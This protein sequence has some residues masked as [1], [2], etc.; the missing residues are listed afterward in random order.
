MPKQRKLWISLAIIAG[1]IILVLISRFATRGSAEK[2]TVAKVEARTIRSSILASGQLIYTNPVELKPEII[3]KIS[4]IPVVEG[5]MV[6]KDQV[7]LRIDP[8]LYQAAVAQATAGVQQARLAIESQK[9]S[10]ANLQLQWNRQQSL[11]KQHLV[12]ANS[13]DQLTN[14][15]DIAKVQLDSQKEAARIAEAQLSQAQQNLSKTVIRSPIDGMV[16]S[17]PVKVGETVITGTNIPGSTL[18]EIADPV[19]VLADVQVDEADIANVKLGEEADINAVSYPNDTFH[20]KV[21]FIAASVTSSTSVSS[22]A[23]TA[24]QGV[25]FE[26]KIGLTDKKLPRVRP[27]MSCRAEIYTQSTPNAIAVPLQAVLYEN[28]PNSKSLEP[29]SGAYVYVIRDGKA[30]KVDVTTGVSSDT[31]QEIASGLKAGET[32][33]TGPYTVLHAL[34]DGVKVSVLPPEQAKAQNPQHE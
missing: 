2:V 9:F 16:T 27:G 26:V 24:Q 33:I 10:V 18:M 19:E 7:V 17:L 14:Q 4:A 22:T 30:H 25:T 21:Q 11:F 12:D 3:G 29:T 8:T 20:G 13:F 23:A 5:Q 6:K 15:L 1:I 34:S 31:Y 32:V 28:N